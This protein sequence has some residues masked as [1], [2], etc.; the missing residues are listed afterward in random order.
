MES[1]LSEA[2]P[3]ISQPL[4]IKPTEIFLPVE[5][6]VFP[7]FDWNKK[8]GFWSARLEVLSA[9]IIECGH[10]HNTQEEAWICAEA[11]AKSVVEERLSR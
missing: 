7:I 9:E 1:A 2:D 10:D 3:W 5:M 11:L 4:Q 6:V 8:Q